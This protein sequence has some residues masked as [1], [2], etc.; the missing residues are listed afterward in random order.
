MYLVCN[1][2]KSTKIGAVF[3]VLEF[4]H[5]NSGF[6]LELVLVSVDDEV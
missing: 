2:S 4:L 1:L 5:P 6:V 3:P